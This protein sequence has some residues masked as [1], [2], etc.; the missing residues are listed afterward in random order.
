MRPPD[1][2]SRLHD[3][4]DVLLDRSA[5]PGQLRSICEALFED[6]SATGGTL[7][8]ESTALASGKALSA[9]DAARCVLDFQRTT[10]LVRAV[11]AA[12]KRQLLRHPVVQLLYAGCGPFAPLLL[13]LLARF[14]AQRLRVQLLDIHPHSLANARSLCVAAGVADR[15]LPDLCADAAQV[16]LSS[17]F[18]PQ[19]LIAELMQRALQH[20]PQLAV[21][22]NLFPQCAAEADLVPQRIRVSA[23]LIDHAREF[24]PNANRLRIHVADLLTVS[25]QSLPSFIESLGEHSSALPCPDLQIPEDAP[26]GL[27]LVLRTCVEAS[28]NDA[29]HDYDSGL[30]YPLVLHS[31]DNMRAGER[32]QCRYRLGA[33]PGFELTRIAAD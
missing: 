23:A 20:E 24:D 3:H 9:I 2:A 25:H 28:E 22:A 17:D 30:T 21:L 31:L 13:P 11:D 7:D 12:I 19:V 5:H 4:G 26:P 15:L 18:R 27:S 6:C 8:S 1:F 33:N 32:I 16:Q 10:V 29:L 14:P